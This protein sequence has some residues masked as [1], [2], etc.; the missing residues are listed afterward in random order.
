MRRGIHI[1]FP[2]AP[3]MALA[4]SSAHYGAVCLFLSLYYGRVGL[5]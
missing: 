4:H 2:P 5:T 3:G 1:H